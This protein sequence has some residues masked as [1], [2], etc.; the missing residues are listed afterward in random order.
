MKARVYRGEPPLP[1]AD[2]LFSEFGDEL[3]AQ[4]TAGNRTR[5]EYRHIQEWFARFFGNKSLRQITVQ[6]CDQALAELS[7]T[8]APNTTAK[9][10]IRLRHVMRRA[11]AYR[12]ITCS[13]TDGMQRLPTIVSIRQIET[14]EIDEIKLLF[15]NADDYWRPLFTLW[16]ATGMRRSEIFGLTTDCLDVA[17]LRVH[18]RRQLQ[19]GKLVPYTKNKTVR[20]IPVADE[21]MEL[22]LEHAKTAPRV[23]S[24]DRLVFPSKTGLPVHYS[25]WNRDVF[26]PLV[27]SIGRPSMVTHD[28]R[29]T[30]ASQ[31]LSQGVNIKTLQVM[32]GHKDASLT[33]N[34]YSHLIPSDGRVAADKM[35]EFLL[36]EE[37][38]TRMGHSR[39]ADWIVNEAA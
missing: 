25:D 10:V 31:A 38:V 29:H 23:L 18:V 30:F 33:L 21:V 16:L 39:V 15:A 36:R 17:N 5:R 22:V 14:L 13:P 19:D 7:K 20:A 2:R 4:C 35:S 24:A 32:L 8:K 26:K 37:T 27:K 1:K 9:Y 34:R 6:D 12:L 28:L 3:L 11:V